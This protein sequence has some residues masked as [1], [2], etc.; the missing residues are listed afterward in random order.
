M[1]LPMPAVAMG[2]ASLPSSFRT[3]MKIAFSVFLVCEV[4]LSVLRFYVF[5]IWGGVMMSLISVF[6]FFVVKYDFDLQWTIMFGMTIFF[7]GLIHFVMMIE[8]MVMGW[9]SFPD[10][11]AIEV[12]VIVR[13]FV[14]ILAPV[15]DWTL[16][17]L[18]YLVFRKT[19]YSGGS[20]SE[21]RQSLIR[22]SSIINASGSFT[23]F[24]GQGRKLA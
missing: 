4:A 18:C 15:I 14:F 3:G 2:P 19:T 24:S 11:H 6:G 21:E 22:G 5:D 7:Y 8:K 10:I 16:T 9:P 12:R 13:D 17:V 20:T 1:V 23:P